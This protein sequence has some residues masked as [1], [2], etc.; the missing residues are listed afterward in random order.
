MK[1]SRHIRLV[2]L[3]S[4]AGGALTGCGPED[5]RASSLMPP[6]SDQMTYTNNHHVPGVGYYHAPYHAWYPFPYNFYSPE[7]GYYHGDRWTREPNQT[8]VTASR[9]SPQAAQTARAEQMARSQ[10]SRGGFGRSLFRS[11]S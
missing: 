11:G 3:G 8:G 6:V 5:D 1:R 10:V 7:R 9:P 2:L 4:L